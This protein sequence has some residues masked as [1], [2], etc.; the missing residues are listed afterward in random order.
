MYYE[1]NGFSTFIF[2]NRYASASPMPDVQ[3]GCREQPKRRGRQGTRAQH[4]HIVPARNA[5]DF[6]RASNDSCS[7]ATPSG[8]QGNST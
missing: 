3:I 1:K 8:P 4:G 2:Y 6:R 7:A 5:Y